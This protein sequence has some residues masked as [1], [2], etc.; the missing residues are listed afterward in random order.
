MIDFMNL[1][2]IVEKCYK[3]ALKNKESCIYIED[4]LV[5]F[6]KTYKNPDFLKDYNEKINLFV[7]YLKEVKQQR[8]INQQQSEIDYTDFIRID[9]VYYH[10]M[11]FDFFQIYSGLTS[12]LGAYSLKDKKE[13]MY[14]IILLTIIFSEN[15]SL[16]TGIDVANIDDGKLSDK[17]RDYMTLS[18]ISNN[19]DLYK[20]ISATLKKL[21]GN[22]ENPDN[23]IIIKLDD[24]EDDEDFS[25]PPNINIGNIIGVKKR[26]N[27]AVEEY[28]TNLTQEV[29]KNFVKMVG[30]EEELQELQEVLLR[31]DKPN[32]LLLGEPGVGKTKLIQGFTK[33][34]IAKKCNEHF[35]GYTVYSLNLLELSS[36]TGLRGQLESN[37]NALIKDLLSK[38]KVILYIDEIHQIK[39]DMDKFGDIASMLKPILTSGKIRVIGSTTESEYRKSLAKDSALERRFKLMHIKEPTIEQTINILKGIKKVYENFHEVKYTAKILN[40]IVNLSDKFI[41]D[42]YFPDKAIDLMDSI[43]AYC[44]RVGKPKDYTISEDDVYTIVSKLANLPKIQLEE[45]EIDKLNKL[46]DTIKEKI[47]GQDKAI[48]ALVNGVMIAK[49]GLREQSKTA[50]TLFF[51]GP[52]GVGKTETIKQLADKLNIPLYRYDMSE[53]MEEHTVSKLIGTPPGYVG[54]Q[55]G[56]AGSGLLVNQVKTTPNCIVLL[57]EIEKANP[58]VLNVFLQIMDNGKITSSSG[59]EADFSNVYLFMTSN[60]GAS[61]SD[62]MASIGFG[63]D[64]SQSAS[65]EFFNSSFSPEFRNRLDGAISF[66]NLS[67]EVLNKITDNELNSLKNTLNDKKVKMVYDTSVVNYISK[68]ASKENLGAR[69]IKRIIHNEIKSIIS[70]ELVCGKLYKGGKLTVSV[71]NES[72]KFKY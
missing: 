23:K 27:S 43:G 8:K 36:D 19:K 46:G 33:A 50:L 3:Q 17:I 37:I 4:I 35:F 9:D 66:N 60:V 57:D 31:R 22:K 30:R 47:I 56:K 34:I 32:V 25:M 10:P 6:F 11:V 26:E 49:S 14:C 67:D 48:D 41:K 20:T 52:S 1:K 42:K 61:A 45:T 71:E 68:K 2:S 54:Y 63:A 5:E 51:K 72:L 16:K 18:T 59:V 55:D 21:I 70:K 15:I 12:I 64:N 44:K 24:N 28:C 13:E 38:E 53:F 40:L 69:P 58:K 62:K 7:D 39:N 65:E 29:S